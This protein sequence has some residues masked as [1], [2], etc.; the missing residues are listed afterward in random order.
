MG[1]GIVHKKNMSDENQNLQRISTAMSRAIKEN[2]AK[3]GKILSS[4]GTSIT[5]EL[6][7]PNSNIL[8]T[9]EFSLF[10]PKSIPKSVPN[11]VPKSVPKSVRK[12][13]KISWVSPKPVSLSLAH[14]FEYEQLEKGDEA[15]FFYDMALLT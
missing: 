3:S 14:D 11:S 9:Q 4:D 7:M 8:I 12:M 13:I 5:V 2:K 6:E 1:N 10:S 15:L